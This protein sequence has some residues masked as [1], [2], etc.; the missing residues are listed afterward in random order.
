VNSPAI[1]IPT[2][3]IERSILLIRGE[4]VMLDADLAEIYGVTTKVLNQAVKRNAIR[5]PEDFMFQLTEREK[6]EVVTNCDHLVR[7][8]FSP[9]LP[10]A[11]TEHGALMLANVLNGERA[12][13]TSVQVVRAFVRLR[14]MLASNAELSRKLAALEKKYDA[15]FKIV[16]DAIRQLMTPPE[17][18]RRKI[19]FH[20]KYDD[21]KP[22]AKKP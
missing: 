3:R 12:A 16:F 21:D 17:P 5:F 20:V 15:Q 19:G 11:F 6:A 10:F 7:I 4:K 1:L 8:K 18:K 9:H 14:Q 13:L 22:K 2:E